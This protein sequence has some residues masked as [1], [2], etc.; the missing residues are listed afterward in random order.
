M[1]LSHAHDSTTRVIYRTA[2]SPRPALFAPR[3]ICSLQDTFHDHDGKP[4]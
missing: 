4:F 3:E 2:V 1:S